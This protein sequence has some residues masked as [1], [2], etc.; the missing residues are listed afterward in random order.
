MAWLANLSVD[1]ELRGGPDGSPRTVAHAVHEGPLRVMQSLYPEAGG[2]CHTVL[3]HPPSGLTGGD[4]LDVRLHLKNGTHSLLTTPGASRFY[5]SDGEAAMQSV[6]AR[7]ESGARLE[8]LPQENIAY[9]GCKAHNHAR[10]D[11]AG[12]AELMAWDITALGLPASGKPFERGYIHQHLELA[13]SWID[14]G[15]IDSGDGRLL[16]SPL[17]LHGHRCL[18]TL[19]FAS[20]EAITRTRREQL[21]D[22]ARELIDQH[23]LRATSAATAANPQVIVVRA[24]APLVEPAMGLFRQIRSAW[25]PALWQMPGTAP[26]VWMDEWK[27]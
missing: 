18:A 8:W 4:T 24:L 2:V 11:L 25:R 19:I 3:V 14:S 6:R 20:G 1:F 21:L 10:F 9:S 17:G 16:N 23:E 7:L 22:L 27:N 26:R 13:G 12:G 5:R 15:R